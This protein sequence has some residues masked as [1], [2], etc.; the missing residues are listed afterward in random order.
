M[1]LKQV[2]GA[3]WSEVCS[4]M[5]D[6]LCALC[7]QTAT[8]FTLENGL[9]EYAKGYPRRLCITFGGSC[10]DVIKM[11]LPWHRM[12]RNSNATNGYGRA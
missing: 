2:P 12:P 1:S 4:S 6:Y 8:R 10:C 5:N 7:T 11:D 9:R 3:R